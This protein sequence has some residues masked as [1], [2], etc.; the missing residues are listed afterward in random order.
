MRNSFVN[1]DK[2]SVLYSCK[3]TLL[4]KGTLKNLGNETRSLGGNKALIV[5]DPGVVNADLVKPAVAS[6]K[7]SG[8]EVGVFDQVQPEPPTSVIDSCA[9]MVRREGFNTIIGLGGGSS[10]D[11]AKAASA[12]ATNPGPVMNTWEWTRYPSAEYPVF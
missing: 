3:K 4:G 2:V 10:L 8:L 12:L 7:E 1:V 11:T 5:T 6:I 9:E